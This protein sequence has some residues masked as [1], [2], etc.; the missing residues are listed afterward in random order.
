MATPKKTPQGTYRIQVEVRGTRDSGTFPT[1]R[2]AREWAVAR[3]AELQAIA[4]GKVGT[5]K[6]LRDALRKYAE[7]VSPTKRGER[8]ELV[9]LQAYERPTTAAQKGHGLPLDAK[10]SEVTKA[11]LVTWRDAR[12]KVTTR[13]TVL[14]DMTLLGNVL[15]VARR[16]WGWIETN[17]MRDVTRPAEPD[18]RTRVITGPEVRNML[19]AL[20]Y[21]WPVRTVGQ[22]VAAC[23]LLALAT[24]MRAGELCALTWADVRDDYVVL[25]TSK[26]G[27]GRHVPLSPVARRIV[28]GMRGWDATSVFGLTPQTLAAM[29]IKYRKRAGLEGFTFHDARHSAATRIAQR[30]H[31]LDLCLVFGWKNPK[32]AM[33]YYQ[34]K[35]SDLAKRL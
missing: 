10:L 21:G 14:R 19:R 24:G 8:W 31:V 9:R 27:A 34:P 2:E 1:A 6:T 26:T 3:K 33:T 32:M 28:E 7:E 35:A 5:V 12:L 11:D 30:L 4:G 22:A 25:H 13:G 20:R 16:E 18:H 29:F 23:F 15:E 17:P